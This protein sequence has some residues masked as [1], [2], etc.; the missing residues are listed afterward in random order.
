MVRTL[1]N[2]VRALGAL[3]RR[4]RA[5]PGAAGL[6]ALVVAAGLVGAGH[7]Y[8]RHQWHAAQADVRDLRLDQARRRLDVCLAVWPRRLDVRL[9]A[10]R[11]ARLGGDFPAAEAHLAECLRLAGGATDDIQVE[12]LLMRAQTGEMDEV[13]GLLELFVEAGH[14]AGPHVLETMA[15]VYMQQLEY[16]PAYRVLSRWAELAPD[17]PRPPHWRGWVFE[18]VSDPTRARQ[19]YERALELDPGLVPVRLRL[20]EMHLEDHQPVEAAAH[21]EHLRARHPDRP[22]VAARLGQC[23]F[24]QGEHAEARR[25]LEEAVARLPDHR[26]VLLH[27]AR[28]DLQDRQPARAEAR[29]RRLL[30][31]DRADTEARYVLATALKHQRRDREAAAALAEYETYKDLLGRSNKLLTDEGRRPSRDP[32]RL[33]ELGVL[34]LRVGQER[35]AVHWLD[36]AL[37]LDPEHQGAHRALA[38]HFEQKGDAEQAAAH[39]R[40]L[41][42]S[43]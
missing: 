29:V 8:V 22:E 20:A 34:L 6:I 17:D 36:Q 33:T 28:L 15:R 24:L 14:P 16:G 7:G 9:L 5:R 18:R 1:A 4:A 3:G 12:F 37:R 25:L 35:Q 43:P 32:D 2:P 23:R 27:L 39:R 26:Y 31:L 38:E 21:L 19:D 10:A 42:E 30:E 41:R 13:A 40:R 11:A